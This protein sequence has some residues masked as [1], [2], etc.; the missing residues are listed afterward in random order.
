MNGFVVCK[1]NVTSSN[2]SI[3]HISVE[4]IFMVLVSHFAFPLN[5]PA[6]APFFFLFAEDL[7]SA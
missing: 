5:F 1:M 2:V 4:H 6:G 3:G 7:S